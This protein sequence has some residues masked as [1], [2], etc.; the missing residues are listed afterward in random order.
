MSMVNKKISDKFIIFFMIIAINFFTIGLV[1]INSMIADA[2][3]FNIRNARHIKPTKFIKKP[4]PSKTISPTLTP[5]PINVI[6]K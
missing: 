4:K 3:T 6:V 2:Y 5:S 1:Y